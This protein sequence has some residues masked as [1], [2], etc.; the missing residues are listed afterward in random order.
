[1]I[2]R[3]RRGSWCYERTKGPKTEY[4]CFDAFVVVEEA[5][6]TLPIGRLFTLAGTRTHLMTLGTKRMDTPGIQRVPTERE[7]AKSENPPFDRSRRL[8]KRL[9]SP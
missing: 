6:F 7:Q 4:G 9:L 1:M 8:T 2:V 3:A 5:K